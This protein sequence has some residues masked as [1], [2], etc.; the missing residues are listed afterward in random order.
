MDRSDSTDQTDL[1]RGT[2]WSMRGHS[3]S[4]NF[5]GLEWLTRGFA[6]ISR[7]HSFLQEDTQTA[8]WLA[9]IPVRGSALLPEHVVYVSE[10]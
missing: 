6:Q 7:Q 9:S 4:C 1:L 3:M 10:M 8:P 5:V 2:P